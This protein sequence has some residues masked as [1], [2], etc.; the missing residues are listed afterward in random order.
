MPETPPQE[1]SVST[2]SCSVRVDDIDRTSMI[3]PVWL[4]CTA[5]N[6]PDTLVYAS[7]D[8]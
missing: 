8:T 5:E 7:L 4:S 3:V 2:F 6:S 1:E